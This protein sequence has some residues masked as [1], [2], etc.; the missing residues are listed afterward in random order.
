MALW[1][2]VLLGVVQGIF[3]FLPVSSTAH[4]VLLEH[5]LI[6]QDHPMPAPESAEMIL[7]NLVVHVGTLVSIVVVFAPSLL[8]F[9]RYSLRDAYGWA[10][11]GR[12]QGPPL[13]ARLFLLGMLSVLFTGV[14]GLTLKAVFEQVFANPWMIGITLILTGALLF[15][16]D[17]LPPRRR[18]LRQTGVGTATIIGIAQGFALMP[19]L[20]RSALTIVFGLFAGLKRRWAAE[21][22]FFLA[23]PTI[24]AATLLQAI[25]VYRLGGL[26]SVSV[27]ALATGFVVAAVVGIVSLKLVIY[28][29]YRA[30]LKVFSF[31]VWALAAAILFGWIDLPM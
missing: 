8:R 13:Y 10:R 15:W 14:V 19:G 31:Y 24:C 18:G 25:E 26:E 12:F 27:A 30:Q 17:K 7:F 9:T 21:Y 5:W 16:T 29:L 2:A 20:S 4:M 23:I 28:F 1:I 11:A 22:S 3:M 6:G